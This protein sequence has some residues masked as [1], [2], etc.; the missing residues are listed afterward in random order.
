MQYMK[1]YIIPDMVARLCTVSREGSSSDVVRA[2]YPFTHMLVP[3]LNGGGD[4]LV[5]RLGYGIHDIYKR[6]FYHGYYPRNAYV[7][8][9]ESSELC[10]IPGN[11]RHAQL[12][13]AL[14]L[15]E[16]EIENYWLH[17][18]SGEVLVLTR[19]K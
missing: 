13:D 9:T 3:D 1:N 17:I 19:P 5:C 18:Y 8:P 12:G 2:A 4:I 7:I 16:H 6:F 15:N 14:I 10:A 11:T